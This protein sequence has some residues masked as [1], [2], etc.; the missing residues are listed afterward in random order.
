MNNENGC[1]YVGVLFS[2]FPHATFPTSSY[3]EIEHKEPL[4]SCMITEN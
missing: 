3:S 4:W 2:K 1:H